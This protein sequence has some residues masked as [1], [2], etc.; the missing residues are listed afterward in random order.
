[1]ILFGKKRNDR[2]TAITLF[3]LFA[4]LFINIY[5]IELPRLR[6]DYLGPQI[7]PLIISA[8][9]MVSAVFLFIFP[10]DN[11][12][13]LEASQWKRLLIAGF[14]LIAYAF[15]FENI[16]F[17][18]S[19]ILISVAVAY[20]FGLSIPK[21]LVFAALLSVLSYILLAGLLELNLP[22]QFLEEWVIYPIEIMKGVR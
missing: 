17:I 10:Q 1:M 3:L 22:Q 15:C 13:P 14:L 7:F 18:A 11:K 2:L 8:L 12:K 19:T 20:I 21:A 9:G 4:F 5:S 6:S 16:G